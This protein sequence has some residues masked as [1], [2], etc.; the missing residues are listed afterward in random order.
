M[1]R[2]LLLITFSF[3]Y[4]FS[5]L[6]VF[7]YH[8]INLL[9]HFLN[10]ILFY[11]LLTLLGSS[12]IAFVRAPKNQSASKPSNHLPFGLIFIT[13]LLFLAHPINTEAVCYI[14]S[15]SDLMVSFFILAG[16]ICYFRKSFFVASVLYLMGILTKETA[17]VFPLLLFFFHYL[18]F[19]QEIEIPRNDKRRLFFFYLF[20]IGISIFYWIYH[21]IVSGQQAHQMVPFFSANPIR[22]PWAN[23][24]TQAAVTVF[25]LKLFLWPSPL[26]IHHAFP[27]LHTLLQPLAFFSII[28]ILM[29][30]LLT[31]T[32]RK[33]R[34]LISIGLG[35][36][37]ICLLPKYYGFLNVVA[38]EHHFYL[39][40]FGIYL[41]LAVLL[42]NLY[43]Q[44]KRHFIIVAA[45]ILSI[46]T[47]LVVFRNNDY[48]NEFTFWKKALEFDSRS[49]L[50][51]HNL[52]IAYIH[53]GLYH[54][55]EDELKKA[56]SV[57]PPYAN[58][59]I[60]QTRENLANVYRLE[61]KFREA[62]D[63]INK[64]ISGG[65]YDFGTFQSIGVIYWDMKNEKKAQEIWEKGLQINPQASG[66]LY[67][68]GLLYTGRKQFSQAKKYFQKAISADPD[69]YA[70]YFG[71]GR[72]LEE[73]GEVNSA[74]K[75]YEQATRL[76]ANFV[77]AHYYLGLLYAKKYDSR[78]LYELKKTVL[79]AP[80]FEKAHN[81]LAVL[82]ASMEPPQMALAREYAQKALSLGYPVDESFLKIIGLEKNEELKK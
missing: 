61:K 42:R 36:Y 47:T 72:I 6:K 63:E 20:L 75:A 19:Q 48:G 8:I 67:N 18:I 46:C 29:L 26:T 27:I 73:T 11:S 44:R 30:A 53:K 31:F 24:L 43:V 39:P 50:A 78:A 40:S 58:R 60:K 55:A 77:D 25:Y 38:A 4:F 59:L 69:S 21:G 14:S 56:L 51:H 54:E 16:V 41:I 33:T 81:D 35:W 10:G 37:L 74:I 13:T 23:I 34:P 28:A 3:N 2:P 80:D 1:F 57:A 5:G 82:Y 7:G 79:L 64:N 12:G 62:L 32:L 22:S 52:G 71:L 49:A 45:G 65:S 17:L 15:R 70:A 76:Q 68:L 9:F 66:I